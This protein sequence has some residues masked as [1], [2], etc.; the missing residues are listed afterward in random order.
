MDAISDILHMIRLKSSVYFRSDFSSPWG[1]EIGSGPFAQFH[2]VVHGHCWLQQE[3]GKDQNPLALSS[4][5]IVVF[6]RG[7]A[8]W[9]ADDPQ[10]KR[11][12]GM[13]V[14]EAFG[15]GEPPFQGEGVPTTLVCGHF[16]FDRQLDHPFLDALPNLILISSAER[17]QLAWLETATNLMM[18]EAGKDNPGSEVLVDRLGEVVFIQVL[19]A[20]M[21]KNK[22]ASGFLAALRD[23]EI[24]HALTL[25]H[26]HPQ[27]NW[28]LERLA[29]KIAISRA[30][31]ASK[32]KRLMGTT[33]MSYITQWR[34]LKARELLLNN[35]LTLPMIAEKVGY[36]SEAA[37]N[38]AFKRQ[39]QQ[40]PGSL[41]KSLLKNRL[42]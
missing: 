16:E 39:F 1:M 31:F 4:G 8:H 23:E 33:P 41:R 22:S 40:N 29:R 7:D 9:L 30:S 28:T 5:D 13:E 15:K 14:V 32:F 24:N 37:F 17:R 2:M 18:D 42:S 19:R 27:T 20:Y 35:Q 26:K 34:M 12:P 36:T 25:I 6:P 38:R 11:V 21:I 3:P 10:H